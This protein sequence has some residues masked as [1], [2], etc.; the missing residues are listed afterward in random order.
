[1]TKKILITGGCGF[2]GTHFVEHLLKNTLWDLTILDNLSYAGSLEHLMD[3]PVFREQRERVHFVYHD[4]RAEFYTSHFEFNEYDYIVHL[5]AFTDVYSSIQNPKDFID[6][7]IIGTYNML[8]YARKVCPER[9]L[10]CSTDEV[11]GPVKRVNGEFELHRE[12]DPHKPSNPYSSSKAAAEDLCYAWH[13]TYGVPV[14]VSNGMNL[15]GERQNVEKFLPK[16]V[17]A[18]LQREP[19]I[20]HVSQ[21]IHGNIT[22]ISSRYWLHAR[23]YADAIMFFLERGEIGEKYNVTGEYANVEEVA[24]MV[25]DI[26]NISKDKRNIVYENCNNSR[27]GHDL[28]YGLDGSKLAALGWNPP[29]RFIPG[30]AKTVIWMRDNPRWLNL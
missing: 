29:V 27:P 23:N 17:R 12:D 26:L 4:F 25:A 24:N 8:E 20:L 22:D 1:M 9:F 5:G 21:D 2:L 18:F 28:H 15:I 3:I 19:I 16:I 13:T 11:Y 30:L 14:I 6:N 10:Y 7:N